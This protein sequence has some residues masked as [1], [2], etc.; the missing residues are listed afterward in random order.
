LE[1]ALYCVK[2]KEV[3]VE[4]WLGGETLHG[5]H[6]AAADTLGM[7]GTGYLCV[8]WMGKDGTSPGRTTYKEM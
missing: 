3:G 5:F 1:R 2:N 7:E 4:W 6:G 8:S